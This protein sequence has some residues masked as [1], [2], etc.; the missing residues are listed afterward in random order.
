M[1]YK[2]LLGMFF[3]KSDGFSILRNYTLVVYIK[4]LI[5]FT[6]FGNFSFNFH[7]VGVVDRDLTLFQDCGFLHARNSVCKTFKITF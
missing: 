1:S 6:G 5:H 3:S 2:L 7:E 4:C